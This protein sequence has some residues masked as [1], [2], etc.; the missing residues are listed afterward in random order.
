[1]EVHVDLDSLV[2]RLTEPEDVTSLCVVVDGPEGATPSSHLH[3][4]GDVVAHRH[5]GH[6]EETGEVAVDQSIIRFL[7]AGEVGDAWE[8]EFS[9]MI[10]GAE[11]K[12]SL[13]PEG[14]IRGYV[15]WPQ[16]ST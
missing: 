1:M 16:R 5:V 8:G 10:A 2:V 4:L 14:R 12:G 13:D 7:A 3:R 6:L 9:A 15:I 11:A